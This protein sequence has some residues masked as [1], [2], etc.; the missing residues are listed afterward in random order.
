MSL[1]GVFNGKIEKIHR[2]ICK[3]CRHY[4]TNRGSLRNVHVDGGTRKASSSSVAFRNPKRSKNSKRCHITPALD[5]APVGMDDTSN[6][7]RDLPMQ[8]AATV[9]TEDGFKS[10][11]SVALRLGVTDDVRGDGKELPDLGQ[12]NWP[13][14]CDDLG[15]F[16]GADVFAD[17]DP[18]PFLNLS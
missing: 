10:T 17:T 4:W 14:S 16:W 5:P 1:G 13:S 7:N 9:D 18:A 11:T 6:S 12:F 3:F 2:K 8:A 15:S